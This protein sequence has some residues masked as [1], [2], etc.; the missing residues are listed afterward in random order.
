VKAEL[1][2]VIADDHPIFRHGLRVVIEAD[3]RLKIVAEAEDGV[4]ALARIRE[5]QPEIAILDLEIP[6]PDGLAVARTIRA[7]RL[8]VEVIFLTMHKDEALFNAALD[9]G[10]K[11][12]VVKDSAAAEIVGCIKTVAAGSSFISPVLSDYLLYRRERSATLVKQNPRLDDLTP[13]ERRVL[14]LLAESKTNKEIARELFVSVRTVEHHRANIC[15]K[16]GLQGHHA[17]ITFAL[18][19]KS[20]I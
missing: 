8:P 14:R 11:G 7:E 6:P 1:R 16:L 2:L 15:V 4:T 20:E 12:Y 5:H 13:A 10:V 9:L 19:H 17:L 3:P 18:A